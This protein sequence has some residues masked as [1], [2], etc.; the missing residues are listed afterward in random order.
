MPHLSR[1]AESL[2]TENAFVVLAEV[3]ALARSARTSSRSASASPT[4]RRR[5]TCRTRRSRPSAPASMATRPARASTSLRAAAAKDLA[6][7]RGLDHR[8]G[9]R[10][11]R[12]GRQALHRVHDRVGH[13]LRRGRRS[14]LS[15]AGLSDLRIADPR[16]RCR[17]GADLP[18]RERALRVRSGRARG[19]DHAE[20]AAP[21]SQHAAES[22]P[23]AFS[24]TPISTRSRRSC[25]RIRRCGCSPTR[26]IRGSSTTAASI[27]SRRAP[28]CSSAR[29]SATARPRPGR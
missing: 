8:A 1:R 26:S 11:R 19:E 5:P 25:A 29:S 23:A 16:Q 4:S 28:T 12:R 18:A 20:D 27:R 24:I 7:R 13:R 2:G 22:R 9:R 10:R 14:H 17:A 15:G 6:T 21:H 3:N